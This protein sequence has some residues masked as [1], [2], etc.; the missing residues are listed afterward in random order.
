MGFGDSPFGS[1]P[2]G[3]DAAV[4]TEARDVTPPAALRLDGDT[5]DFR[6]DSKGRYV[7]AHPVDTKVWHR[8]RIV[9]GSMRSAPGT[10]NGVANRAYIDPLT[11]ESSVKDQVRLAVEDMIDAGDIEDR[12]IELDLSVRGRVS[13]IYN[14]FNRRSGK[15]GSFRSPLP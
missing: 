12:G 2:F 14:Y 6:L 1:T 10:G 9:A 5:K 7:A 3:L 11:I 4:E 8:L 15:P 13:Y